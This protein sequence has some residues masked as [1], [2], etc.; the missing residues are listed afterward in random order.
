M[1]LVCFSLCVNVVSKDHGLFYFRVLM[2]IM[3]CF[4]E[5]V[6]VVSWSVLV[7]VIMLTWSVLVLV[8][9]SLL[10]HVIHMLSCALA[11]SDCCLWFSPVWYRILLAFN[12]F[13]IFVY[14]LSL[15]CLGA[16]FWDALWGSHFSSVPSVLPEG[17]YLENMRAHYKVLSNMEYIW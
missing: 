11:V 4:R 3:V 12:T 5:C 9:I 8:L 13:S 15:L 17:P 2:L 16:F 1:L 6:N 10:V 7:S 14:M